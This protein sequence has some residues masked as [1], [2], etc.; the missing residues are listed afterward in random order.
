MRRSGPHEREEK[1]SGPRGKF[2]WAEENRRS[3]G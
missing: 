3:S 1:A 2:S